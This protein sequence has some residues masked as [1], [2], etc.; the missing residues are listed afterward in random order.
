MLQSGIESIKN[1]DMIE[2][3]EVRTKKIKDLIQ[4]LDQSYFTPNTKVLKV[5]KPGKKEM[6]SSVALQAGDDGLQGDSQ[7]EFAKQFNIK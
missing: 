5:E 6:M 4:D 3:S 2:K 1:S 7:F